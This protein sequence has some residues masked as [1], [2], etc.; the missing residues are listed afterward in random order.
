MKNGLGSG[1]SKL[2]TAISYL[3]MIGVVASLVLEVIGM[4]LFYQTYGQLGISHDKAVLVQG[5]DF[6]SFIFDQLRGHS[7]GTA[8]RFMTLGIVVLLLTPYLRVVLSAIYFGREK[9]YKYV[10]ITIFVLIVLTLSLI[11]H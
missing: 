1:E 10:I 9:N 4:A 8:I 11:L 3:L 6:F 5:R 2:E 7:E